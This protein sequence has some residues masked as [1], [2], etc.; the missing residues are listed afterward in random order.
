MSEDPPT[1]I[2]RS[3]T[4]CLVVLLLVEEPACDDRA[5]DGADGHQPH[6]QPLYGAE[7]PPTEEHALNRGPQRDRRRVGGAENHRHHHQLPH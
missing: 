6:D 5:D 3:D 7:R 1:S 4:G 2:Q